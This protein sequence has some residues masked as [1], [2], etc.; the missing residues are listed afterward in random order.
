MARDF[1]FHPVQSEPYYFIS[2]NSQDERRVGAIALEMHRRGIPMWYDNGL[3][4]GQKWETQIASKIK[5]CHGVVLF[6]T[7]RLMAR[8]NSYVKKEFIFAQKYHKKVHIVVL[9]DIAFEDVNEELQGWFIDLEELHGIYVS[10][11]SDLSEIVNTMDD[12][13]HFI[14]LSPEELEAVEL[15]TDTLHHRK[16]EIIALSVALAVL[17]IVGLIT[18]PGIIRYFREEGVTVPRVKPPT[19]LLPTIPPPQAAK[20]RH[21]PCR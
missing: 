18:L 13:I 16:T 7:K 19:P 8:K 1:G 9:D 4:T 3:L 14:K 15:P 17:L 5:H 21:L 6:V 20:R 10:D 2:Y 11:R 12:T